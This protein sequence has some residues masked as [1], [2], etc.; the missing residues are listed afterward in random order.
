MSSE[1][2]DHDRHFVVEVAVDG[3][4]L[5]SGEGRNRREAETQAAEAA[6]ERI[7]SDAPTTVT[8]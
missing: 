1:G 8:T 2:P 5:G 3:D 6:L 4:V 7:D